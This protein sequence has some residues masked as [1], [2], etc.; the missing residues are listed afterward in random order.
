MAR[1]LLGDFSAI[2]RLGLRDIFTDD[3]RNLVA[4]E[5]QNDGILDR[6][7]TVLPDVVVLD[8][9]SNAGDGL[10]RQ[11]A[12]DYPAVKVVAC[13]SERPQMR[14]F[15]PFHHGES[16]V[17]ELNPTSLVEVVRNGSA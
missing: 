2:V 15:P 14:V 3:G 16:Y 6:L 10:A 13:S 1:V 8:L 7:L 12:T 11:I 5:T 4:E 9:D 17:L